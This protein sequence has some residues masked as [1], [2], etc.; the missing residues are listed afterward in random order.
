MNLSSVALLCHECVA[1]ARRS[2]CAITVAVLSMVLGGSSHPCLAQT[3]SVL[4][5]FNWSDGALPYA[6]L[7]VDKQGNMYGTTSSGGSGSGAGAV[8]ELTPAGTETIL[9]SFGNLNDGQ[10]P[11]GT[12]VQDA[13]GNLYGTTEW[14]GTSGQGT[15]F[16][17]TPSGT[18]T[19][20][21]NFTGGADGGGP[22]SGLVLGR[23]GK[24]YG[25]TFYGGLIACNSGCGTVFEVTPNGRERVLYSFTG[26][27]DGAGPA[28]TSVRDGGGN[29]YGTT[30]N[31][32]LIACSFGCGVV[33]E[34]TK[35]GTEKTLYSFQ[36]GLDASKP[37]SN[38]IVDKLGHLYGTTT[39]GGSSGWGTVFELT[40][41]GTEKVLYS[42]TGLADGS[43]PTSGLL[44]DENGNLYG[45]TR[46]GGAV[47]EGAVF[48]LTPDGTEV[49]LH[50]FNIDP[51]GST[52]FA[53]LVSDHHGHLIGTTVNGG[54]SG[55]G[56]VFKVTP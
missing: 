9:Y 1:I 43:S 35:T 51:D 39:L 46:W 28:G 27:A 29:L 40:P 19:V 6:G 52:P 20:L 23:N 21:Y 13:S 3:E 16:K 17:V 32:G 56:T 10:Y 8:F 14:G 26:G 5:S 54:A 44:R 55:Y 49:V 48:K 30:F 41:A 53:G 37:A 15:V 33:F 34:I 45:T 7:I 36:G 50:S 42:F 12:L 11:M 2:C 4:F 25:T 18:E 31:G 24:L 22:Q 47:G 38:L